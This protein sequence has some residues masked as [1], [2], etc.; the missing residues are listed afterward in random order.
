MK[1]I[2]KIAFRQAGYAMSGKGEY[3]FFLS[4]TKC[5]KR[6]ATFAIINSLAYLVGEG[7][8]MLLTQSIKKCVFL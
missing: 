8:F 5:L 6:N 2:R 4:I 3:Q 1:A 7:F